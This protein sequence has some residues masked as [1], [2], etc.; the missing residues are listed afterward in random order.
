MAIIIVTKLQKEIRIKGNLSTLSFWY[1]A[2]N[3]KTE[4]LTNSAI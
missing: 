3:M 2:A 1:P 4:K